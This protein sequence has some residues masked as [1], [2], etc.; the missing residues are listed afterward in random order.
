M[1]HMIDIKYH[2]RMLKQHGHRECEG[3]KR[4]DPLPFTQEELH[5]L[6][7]SYLDKGKCYHCWDTLDSINVSV[8]HMMA[9]SVGGKTEL[10]NLRPICRSCNMDKNHLSDELF[11]ERRYKARLKRMIA[12]SLSKLST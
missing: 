2:Y 7:S 1:D 3:A 6:I 4:G 10:S 9:L 8:D 11:H 5:D 12:R